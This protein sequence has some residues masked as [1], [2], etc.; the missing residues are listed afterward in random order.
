MASKYLS[1]SDI[2]INH[3][4]VDQKGFKKLY[5]GYVQEGCGSQG[6]EP[7]HLYLKEKDIVRHFK[8]NPNSIPL[9][10]LFKWA[11][12]NHPN[13]MYTGLVHHKFTEEDGFHPS[14][15]LSGKYQIRNTYGWIEF[16]KLGDNPPV[17]I[18]QPTL[19]NGCG[20]I[21]I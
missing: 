19:I 6:Y 13:K 18:W 7:Y 16:M 11:L 12:E 20:L 3:W 10:E 2:K 15:P 21:K 17:P 1:D 5:L 8:M 4:Y 9:E 14:Q